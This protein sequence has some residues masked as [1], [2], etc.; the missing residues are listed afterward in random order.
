[1]AILSGLPSGK[2]DQVGL[3]VPDLKCA[4]D[5]Y[6]ATLGVT[7]Q[8][9]E[10]NQTNSTFSRSS[11]KFRTRI[12]VAQVGLS[13]IELIQPVSGTTVH[14]EHLTLRGPGIHHFGFY[15]SSLSAAKK[16]LKGRGYTMLVEGRIRGL[17]KLAYFEAPDM[18]CIVEALE[19]SPGFPL[20]LAVNAT[21]YPD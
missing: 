3:L 7:F 17:R 4:M 15:V 6:V 1:M 16:G 13:S 10:V 19:L 21:S 18:H 14:S 11:A 2:L 8:V 5:G 12:A 20:F 9:F